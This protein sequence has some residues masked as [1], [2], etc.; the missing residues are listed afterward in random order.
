MTRNSSRL[1]ATVGGRS[2]ARR[3]VLV[4]S[5]LA[6]F[7]AASIQAAAKSQSDVPVTVSESDGIYSVAAAFVV[8]QPA[9]VVVAAL[10][11]YSQIPTFMPEVRRSDVLERSDEYTVVEQ[12]AVARFMMFSRRVHLVLEVREARG[13]I[14]FRDRCGKSFARYEGTWTL[15]EHAGRTHVIYQLSAQPSFEVPEFLL[16]RLLKR[17]AGDM[18]ERLKA[19]IVA[20]ADR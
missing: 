19:E 6:L 17:D 16:K 4:T 2:R 8:P 9:S 14:R 7:T 18:I 11:D 15:A 3:L 10:T 20:R 5:T 12:E 1:A 13:T